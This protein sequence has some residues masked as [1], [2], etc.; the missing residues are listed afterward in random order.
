MQV[1]FLGAVEGAGEVTGSRTLLTMPDGLNILV[2]F[3]MQQ[4]NIG[5]LGETLRWNGRDFEFDIESIDCLI[6]THGHHDHIGGIPLLTTR[7]FKGKIIATAPTAEFCS[8][9]LPDSAKI[10]QSDCEWANRRRP[11]NKLEPLFTIDDA[12][13]SID[14]IQC[15]DYDTAI[16]LSDSTTVKLKRTGHMLGACMPQITY[17]D[18]YGKKQTITF[19]GDTSAKNSDKPFLNVADDIGDTDYIVTEGTYGDK[20]HSKDNPMEILRDAVLQTC[21]ENG[22]TLVVPIF[23]LQRSSE[24]IWLLREIY[25]ENKE[26]YKRIPIYLDSPMAIKAQDIMDENREYWGSDWLDRDNELGNIFEWE[27]LEYIKDHRESE[28]LNNSDPKI[29]LSSSGMASGGRVLRH[30]QNFLPDRGSKVLFCGYLVEGTLGRR[31]LETEKKSIAI[32]RCQVTIRADVDRFSMS[33]HADKNQLTEWLK[34]SKKSKL[35]K[36]LINH[37]DIDAVN[38]LQKELTQHFKSVDVIVPQYNEVI[39]L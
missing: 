16:V 6:L 28:L 35:K 9:S 29:I 1:K 15:Y 13:A 11:K 36:I 39:K 22:K 8:L 37:G 4:S 31:L 24:I 26:L 2:D 12:K 25:I 34:T 23:S 33:S 38:E 27:V 17:T 20:I 21:I 10:M 3:G 18:E 30:L 14:R 5:N 7:G 32:N 19:T